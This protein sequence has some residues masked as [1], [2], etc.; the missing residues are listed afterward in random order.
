MPQNQLKATLFHKTMQDFDFYNVM[1]AISLRFL[2]HL[3]RNCHKEVRVC[4]NMFRE[5]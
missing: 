4:N 2:A 3:K 1:Q 5:V